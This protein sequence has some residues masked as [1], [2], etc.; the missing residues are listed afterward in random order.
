M[1]GPSNVY[2]TN[3]KSSRNSKKDIFILARTILKVMCIRNISYYN[4]ITYVDK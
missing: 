3:V 2:Y 4:L 1:P